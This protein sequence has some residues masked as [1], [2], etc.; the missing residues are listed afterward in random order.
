MLVK[1]DGHNHLY[2]DTETM[3]LIN[4]DVGTKDEYLLKK[5]LIQSQKHEIN[6]VKQEMES[7]KSDMQEIKQMM[8]LLLNKGSNG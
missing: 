8:L 6:N 3:A 7:I 2:R 5:R 4:K 1:I